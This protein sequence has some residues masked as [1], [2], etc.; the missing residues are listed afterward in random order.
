MGSPARVKRELS[1]EQQAYFS[2]NAQ[3]YVDNA[4]RYSKGLQ[5]LPDE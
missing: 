3:H 4:L 5:A 2:T 1:A